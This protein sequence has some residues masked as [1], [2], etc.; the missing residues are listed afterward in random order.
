MNAGA[1]LEELRSMGVKVS[2]DGGYLDLDA[3]TGVLSDELVG[4]VQEVKPDLLLL[5]REEH[6]EPDADEELLPA[7]RQ[8]LSEYPQMIDFPAHYLALN[9]TIFGEYRKEPPVVEVESALE[10]LD[11]ERGAA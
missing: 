6:R 7:L 8:M 1:V 10:G 3:P 9:L 5:V 2:S 11:V 4:R